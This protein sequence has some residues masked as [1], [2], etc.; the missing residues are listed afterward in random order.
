MAPPKCLV[1]A[2]QTRTELPSE[3][4]RTLWRDWQGVKWH[5]HSNAQAYWY[6]CQACH[7]KAWPRDGRCRGPNCKP[8]EAAWCKHRCLR[9][10]AAKLVVGDFYT[11]RA[12]PAACDAIT[13]AKAASKCVAPP[14]PLAL[15]MHPPDIGCPAAPVEEQQRTEKVDVVRKRKRPKMERVSWC[16]GGTCA[17][18]LDPAHVE[19]LE[20]PSCDRSITCLGVPT[21]DSCECELDVARRMNGFAVVLLRSSYFPLPGVPQKHSAHL[22]VACQWLLYSGRRRV[23]VVA[24]EDTAIPF[25]SSGPVRADILAGLKGISLKGKFPARAHERL[26]LDV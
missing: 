5:W 25:E 11:T 23:E 17:S 12:P 24:L 2:K 1:C 18:K 4:L 21:C 22:C 26:W 10:G 16:D 15:R 6:L 19:W 13:A 8:A 20:A 9:D 14:T 3:T 7:V